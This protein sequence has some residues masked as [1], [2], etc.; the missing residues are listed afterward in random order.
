[1]SK[2]PVTCS[3]QTEVYPASG[4]LCGMYIKNSVLQI[5]ANNDEIAEKITE[6]IRL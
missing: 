6:I 3:E 5:C 4:D 1:M 2:V